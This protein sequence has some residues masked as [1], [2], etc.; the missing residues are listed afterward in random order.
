[1]QASCQRNG[2]SYTQSSASSAGIRTNFIRVWLDRT[3]SYQLEASFMIT[4]THRYIWRTD[5]IPTFIPKVV[6]HDAI[7]QRMEGYDRKSSTRC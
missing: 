5:T 6:L 2:F 1:M 3:S 7:L 4:N